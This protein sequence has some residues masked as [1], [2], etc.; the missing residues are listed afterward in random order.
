MTQARSPEATGAADEPARRRWRSILWLAVRVSVTAGALYWTL[1][2]VSVDEMARAAGRMTAFAATV[3]VGLFFA[4][5]LLGAVRWRVLM[6]AYGAARAPRLAFLARVYLVSIFYNTFL[7]GNV[8]GD[9][10][11]GHVTRR[12]FA[13]L[14][15]SYVIVVIERF[16]GLAGLLLLAASVL[17]VHPIGGVAGLEWLALAGIAAALCAAAAPV[18]AR[19]AAHR[20]P[21]RLGEMAAALPALERPSSLA[22]VLLLSV[23]TQT[24]VA[25]TGHVLVRAIDPGVALADSLVLVPVA[26]AAMYFPATVAGLGVREAA[27]VLLFTQVGVDRADATAASLAFLAAQLV[28]AATGGLLHA[29]WP[30]RTEAGGGVPS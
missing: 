25:L 4:N 14:A 17:L 27:F 2:R 8:G 9:V 18:V 23:G 5:L 6:H 28:V 22:W 13:G 7:P 15:G 26:L 20:L 29:V 1:S 24:V 16:F 3:A 11:R 30:L 21:G 19:R 10:L 12:A